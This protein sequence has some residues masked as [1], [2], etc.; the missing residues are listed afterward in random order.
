MKI[1][2][3]W[4]I[5]YI[6]YFLLNTTKW[7]FIPENIGDFQSIWLNFHT[8]YFWEETRRKVQ[9]D[10]IPFHFFTIYSLK[11]YSWNN[12]SMTQS[13]QDERVNIQDL[14]FLDIFLTF[15][16]NMLMICVLDPNVVSRDL[17]DH[18]VDFQIK[19]DVGKKVLG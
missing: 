18:I 16:L 2:K 11:K 9:K 7:L 17:F 15:C 19:S 4:S 14:K 6:F 12:A 5:I 8:F 1:F 10:S 13:L 3:F